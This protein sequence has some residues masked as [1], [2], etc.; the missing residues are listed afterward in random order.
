M[1]NNVCQVVYGQ[2]IVFISGGF[3]KAVKGRTAMKKTVKTIALSVA[4]LTDAG[5]VN[6]QDT[7]VVVDIGLQTGLL[8]KLVCF[9]NG[10]SCFKK[11]LFLSELL[12]KYA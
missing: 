7:E 3:I 8:L 9:L 5:M 12:Y 10:Y 11:F 2:K 1:G 6:T 4:S